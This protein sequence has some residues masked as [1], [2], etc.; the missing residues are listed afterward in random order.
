VSVF[1]LPKNV[2]CEMILDFG[3]TRNRLT[4]VSA[5]VLLPVVSPTMPDE[6]ASRCFDLADEFSPFHASCSSAT[7]RTVGM[8]PLVTS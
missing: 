5:W 7:R 2:A 3:M 6:D 8:F 4:G 1:Q